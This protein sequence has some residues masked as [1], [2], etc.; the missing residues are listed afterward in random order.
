[1]KSAAELARKK[2]KRLKPCVHGGEVWEIANETGL[3]VKDLIDF[4]SSINPLGPSPRALEAIKNSFEQLPLYPDSNSTSL[5]EAIAC[6][7][8]GINKDNVIVGNGSTELNYLFAQVFLKNGDIAVVPAP[9]FG[10][11]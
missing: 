9:T 5:R 4:S 2:V 6:H 10:E 11:D 7:F 8:A 3:S 1:M